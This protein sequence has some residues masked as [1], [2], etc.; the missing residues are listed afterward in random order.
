MNRR[1]IVIFSLLLLSLLPLQVSAEGYG[2]G[3]K[4]ATNHEQP[5]VGMYKPILDKYNGYY[6]DESGDKHIYLTFDNGY[7]AGYTE[8]IL[9]VLKEKQVPATFFLTG[10][11]IDDQ[12][13]LVKRMLQDGHIIGNHSNGHKDFTKLTKAELAA[14]LESLTKKIKSVSDKAVVQYVRPPSGTF[15]E[16]SL[17]WANELGY[18]H[19]FWSLAFVDWNQGSEK[20]W[21]HAYNEVMNQIHPGAIILMHTVS[22]DNADAL[23]SLIN[24]L[25]QQ[26]YTFKSLDD[27]MMKELLPK[28]IIGYSR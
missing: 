18:T 12:K 20:G 21:R 23:E 1:I 10:H 24:D 28:P 14:D 11:Y 22:Q 16:K 13:N 5:D 3:Y 2:W 6:V 9:D 25:R 8:Q 17:Q 4:K 26:G 7:E 27:L 19:I 15:S